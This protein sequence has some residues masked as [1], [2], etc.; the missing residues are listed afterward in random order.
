MRQTNKIKVVA[1]L[2]V[3]KLEMSWLNLKDC[4]Y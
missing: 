2:F 3:I 4:K 1:Y